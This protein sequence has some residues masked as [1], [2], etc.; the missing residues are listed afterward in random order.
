MGLIANNYVDTGVDKIGLAEG[1]VRSYK[2]F[3][4]DGSCV[5]PQAQEKGG[6]IAT[7]ISIPN[8]IGQSV[9][10]LVTATA[11]QPD[12]IGEL[13]PGVS[14]SKVRVEQNHKYLDSYLSFIC[15]TLRSWLH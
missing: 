7:L 5:F 11:Y 14:Y 10:S 6:I 1:E 2:T 8:L 13:P 9:A 15:C 4:S 3:K 12:R